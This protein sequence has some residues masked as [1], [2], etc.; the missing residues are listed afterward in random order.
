MVSQGTDDRRDRASHDIDSPMRA[1]VERIVRAALLEDLGRGDVTSASCVP[2]GAVRRGALVARQDLVVAGLGVA[3]EVWNQVDP[4]LQVTDEAEDGAS[5]AMGSVVQRVEGSAR[6]VLGGE[7]VA[8]NFLQRLCGIATLARR[9]VSALPPDAR[10]RITDTRKTTPLLRALERYAVRCGGA[11]NHR[12]DLGAGI[13]IKDNHIVAAGGIGA[14]VAAARRR[15]P[16]GLRIEVEVQQVH[17]IDEA[18]AA[19]ADV[20]LL[21]NFDDA[22]LHAAVER[23]AGRALVEVS[24]GVTV[25]RVAAI[26]AAGVDVISVGALTHS[27]PAADLA[28]DLT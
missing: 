21:D 26:A 12:E 13:L 3:R 14:A 6:S 19:R 25:A 11:S 18:L 15:A 16:H 20:I 23:I 28:L 2:S 17:E 5:V 7:R 9:Y 27:A 22:Q 1:V 10:A 24:G 4:S 8:L